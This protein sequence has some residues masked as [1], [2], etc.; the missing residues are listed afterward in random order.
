MKI[1]PSVKETS[2]ERVL[3]KKRALSASQYQKN[4]IQYAQ[5]K[6]NDYYQQAV[7]EKESIYQT[8]Y[9]QG[10][11]DGAK[12]LL[13]DF[14]ESLNNSEIALQKR[15]SQSAEQLET[16]LVKLFSDPHIKDIVAD[17]FLHQQEN[18][19][20]INLHLP[21]DMQ[22]FLK[23]Q[24]SGIQVQTNTSS[25]TIALE[26]DNKICYFSPSIAAKN[27]LPQIFSVA[28]RCQIIEK[29][30]KAYQALITLLNIHRGEHDSISK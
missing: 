3:I 2:Q 23:E 15:L 11:N 24:H 13:A 4:V 20:N 12:Q 17:Y 1:P 14:I 22:P 30:K 25:T 27:T 8:A 16:L 19:C 9:Q 18:P 29:R 10:Y 6:A 26:V 5:S 21:A 7:S 28:N